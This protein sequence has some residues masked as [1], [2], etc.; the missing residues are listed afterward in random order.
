M[1]CVEFP[2]ILI[3][4]LIREPQSL[5]YIEPAVFVALADRKTYVFVFFCSLSYVFNSFTQFFFCYAC[6]DDGKF[7][8]AGTV[9]ITGVKDFLKSLG[10]V[11][12]ECIAFIMAVFIVYAF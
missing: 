4:P 6:N 11:F 1:C 12:Q 3:H 2:L 10:S 8:S 5:S 7:V 9:D